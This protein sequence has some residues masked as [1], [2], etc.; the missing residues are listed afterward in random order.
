MAK[1]S[2]RSARFKTIIALI[3][4]GNQYLFEG[5]CKGTIAGERLG[6]GGFGYDPIFIPAGHTYSFGQMSGKEKNEISHRKRALYKMLDF[7]KHR[8]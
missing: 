6:T 3:F 8:I 1:A 2:N 5:L 7:F 4:E